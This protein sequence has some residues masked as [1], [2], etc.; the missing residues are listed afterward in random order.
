MDFLYS[1]DFI[2]NCIEII[3]TLSFEHPLTGI[4]VH[5][6]KTNVSKGF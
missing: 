4:T 6:G 2:Q 3:F 1:F 5:W